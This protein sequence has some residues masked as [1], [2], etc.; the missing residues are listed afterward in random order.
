[1]RRKSV[2]GIKHIG[3]LT[4]GGDAPGM[5]AAI[6]AVVRAAADRKWRVTGV[7]RGYWG[8]INGDSH[9]LNSRSVGGIINRGGTILRTVRCPEF[10][11]ASYRVRAYQH[12]RAWGLEGLVVIG[13]NGSAA[14]ANEINRE[15][16]LP[17]AVVPASIDN[18]VFGTD[19]T[20]G[21]DSAVNTAV[22]AIDQIRD[23]ATSHERVFLIEVMG[24]HN[25]FIAVEV[26][27]ACGAE[28]VLVPE[29][30]F[31][32]DEISRLLVNGKKR[33]KLSS[34]LVMA[35]GAGDSRKITER[36]RAQT[37]LRVRLSIL[38]YIQRGGS[39]SARS[40][41]LAA[42]LGH[43]AVAQLA[44]GQHAHLSAIQDGRLTAVPLKVVAKRTKHIER[45]LYRLT[46]QLA[47]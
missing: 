42:R 35:E 17:V 12:I 9:P 27:L 40:R 22:S 11:Q 43:A 16:G 30:P 41:L 18:D 38:G 3:V 34:I 1:M 29:I 5:N 10:K 44:H 19:D 20:V 21:F 23:T 6:R 45:A 46:N 13:G 31:R 28:A 14:A 47:Q 36:I 37:G 15:T 24:R 26:G 25:G 39:P 32:L 7:L 33:G 4:S 8:L 2:K